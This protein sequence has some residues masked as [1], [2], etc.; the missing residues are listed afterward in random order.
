MSLY[1][2]FANKQE[3]LD[4]MYAEISQRLYPDSGHAT[5]QD[6]LEAL[7]L[8]VR[9][10]LLSHPHWTPLLSRPAPP[11]AVPVRERILELM[12]AAGMPADRALARL[13]S[14]ILVTFGLTFVELTFRGADG[15]SSLERRFEQAKAA[16]AEDKAATQ[17]PTTRSAFADASFEHEGT[18][19]RTL[20]ALIRGW[21]A[22]T[23]PSEPG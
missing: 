21:A 18:F 22:E 12:V 20:E 8:H 10:T 16:F 13:T 17:N 5:W 11:A 6:E 7:A 15:S 19:R 9:R 3:L 2:H 14:A 1:T 4:L 23:R